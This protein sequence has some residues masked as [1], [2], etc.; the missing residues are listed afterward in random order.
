VKSQPS[1]GNSEQAR[2][3]YKKEKPWGENLVFDKGL[4]E[5]NSSCPSFPIKSKQN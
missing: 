2:L 4:E 5:E 1:T 3:L